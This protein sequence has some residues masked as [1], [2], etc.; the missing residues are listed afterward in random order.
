VADE[1]LA[2]AGGELADGAHQ[3]VDPLA[4]LDRRRNDLIDGA[5]PVRFEI[6]CL[7]ARSR[8]IDNCVA[9]DREQPGPGVLGAGPAGDRPMGAEQGLLDDILGEPRVL[10][11]LP[12]GKPPQRRPVKLDQFLQQA[13]SGVAPRKI[14]ASS[15]EH[16]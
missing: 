3:P 14:S 8:G 10:S 1:G 9:D 2:L 7:P 4:L 13:V 6:A 15:S 11:K 12:G 5:V 16:I